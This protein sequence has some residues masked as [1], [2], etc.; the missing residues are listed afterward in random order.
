ML[1]RVELVRKYSEAKVEVLSGKEVSE[2][3][4]L[5]TLFLNSFLHLPFGPLPWLQAAIPLPPPP[6]IK[7]SSQE[8]Q[9]HICPGALPLPTSYTDPN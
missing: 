7:H 9:P 1:V 4:H 5:V 8:Q 6:F 2:K 3:K